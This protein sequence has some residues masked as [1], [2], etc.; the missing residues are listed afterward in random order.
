V[1]TLSTLTK[2]QNS[3]FVPSLG[4][5]L[6][7]RPAYRISDRPGEARTID[8]LKASLKK[9]SAA[10]KEEDEKEGVSLA[11]PS[12]GPLSRPQIARTSTI[13]T[14]LTEGRYAVLPDGVTLADWTHEEKEELDDLVRHK[15]HSRQERFKR[16]MR[17]FGQYVRRR[18]FVHQS[19]IA[20]L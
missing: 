2:V 8:K 15:L 6:N 9:I 20:F 11:G 14:T 1:A 4:K 19:A 7:R 12:G 10:V 5:V 3:L 18:K 16:S 13:P 17:G